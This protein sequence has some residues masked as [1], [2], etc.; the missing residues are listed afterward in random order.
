ML[1]FFSTLYFHKIQCWVGGV[2]QIICLTGTKL[3][4]TYRCSNVCILRVLNCIFSHLLFLEKPHFSYISALF[5]FTLTAVDMDENSKQ[6]WQH[7]LST[8]MF[9]KFSINKISSSVLNSALLT[10]LKH[11]QCTQSPLDFYHTN[12]SQART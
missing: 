12:D 6:Q 11:G 4:N 10:F 5:F 3:L 8:V 9:W 1:S 7:T 2:L